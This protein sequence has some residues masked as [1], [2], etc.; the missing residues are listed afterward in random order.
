M[1][2]LFLPMFSFII[3]CILINGLITQAEVPIYCILTF[4]TLVICQCVHLSVSFAIIMPNSIDIL[5]NVSFEE[6]PEL[7]IFDIEQIRVLIFK[8][9]IFKLV[10][11]EEIEIINT[12]KFEDPKKEKESEERYED[13]E[14]DSDSNETK[15][16]QT[17]ER[18]VTQEKKNAIDSY[19]W[20]Q[21][22]LAKYKY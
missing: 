19:F 13:E 14:S 2:A 3:F 7:D 1:A 18:I 12:L 22:K 16:V 21:K 8:K 20:T 6:Y 4:F 11:E 10:K 9:I 15:T 5:K 17:Q